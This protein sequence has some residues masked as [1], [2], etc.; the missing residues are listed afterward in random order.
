[1]NL[2]K[3]IFT[4][5]LL[6]VMVSLVSIAQDA[7]TNK[8]WTRGGV[9]N[10][11]ISQTGL[12]NWNAGGE[13][14]ISGNVLV[15]YSA[16]YAKDKWKWD[17][18]I[19][20]G[21]GGLVA[22]DDNWKKTDD[23]IELNTKVGRKASEKWFYSGFVNFR[24]QFVEGFK[25]PDDSTL[26]SDWMAPGYITIGLGAEYVPNKFF[27]ANISPLAGKITIVNDQTLADLGSFGVDAAEY[28]AVT[29]DKTKDGAR[30]RF[31]VGANVSVQFKKE[32]VKNVTLDTKLNLFSNYLDNPQNIDVN[33]DLL[34]TMK[35]NKWL[36]AS[37]ITNLIY[38]H[39]VDIALD[40][41][42]D[43]ITDGVGPRTQFKEVVGVGLNLTF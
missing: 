23:R 9:F 35:V 6:G 28:D 7:D 1:M 19:T 18:D 22:G 40:R 29:G 31:E 15:K 5:T 32:I 39:D 21:Y 34:L 12:V 36:S 30:S 13:N 8:Y 24:T 17:N 33:W 10:L 27:S 38:D 37:L 16:N 3:R 2:N 43:G 25:Y 41:N 20:V 42:D 26:I 4:I 11:S 14:N